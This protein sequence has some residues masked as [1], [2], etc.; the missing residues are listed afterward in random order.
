MLTNGTESNGLYLLFANKG[1][2]GKRF[3]APSIA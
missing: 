3:E 2:C 1:N